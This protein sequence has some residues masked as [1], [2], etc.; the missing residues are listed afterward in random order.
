MESS[1]INIIKKSISFYKSRNYSE[2]EMIHDIAETLH[3][4]HADIINV[5]HSMNES[6]K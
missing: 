1:T 4:S 3:V 6:S 5:L 2:E